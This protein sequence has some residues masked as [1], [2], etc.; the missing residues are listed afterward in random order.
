MV[1]LA[2]VTAISLSLRASE[3]Q[4][5]LNVAE[6]ACRFFQRLSL[7]ILKQTDRNLVRQGPATIKAPGTS[8][9]RSAKSP[10]LRDS[11]PQTLNALR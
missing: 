9:A 1:R 4:H 5:T 2:H 3:V 6:T 10:E 8:D 7:L 11:F